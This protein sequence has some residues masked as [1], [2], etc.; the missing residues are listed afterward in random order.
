MPM[1]MVGTAVETPRTTD[2]LSPMLSMSEKIQKRIAMIMTP[3]NDIEP[4]RHERG[5]GLQRPYVELVACN[6]RRP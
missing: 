1:E 2:A 6:A 4:H 5:E 3:S